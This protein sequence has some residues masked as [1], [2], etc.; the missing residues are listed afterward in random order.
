MTELDDSKQPGIAFNYVILNRSEFT[1][2]IKIEAKN[3]L[4]ISFECKNSLMNN[5]SLLQC[6]LTAEIIEKNGNFKLICSMIGVFSEIE[7]SK[8]MELKGFAENN[9]PGLVFPYLREHIT[10]ITSKAGL[11]PIILPPVNIIAMVKKAKEIE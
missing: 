6:E 10:S 2:N 8:N 5:D 3:E 7:S 4:A 11:Q 1:R 9:A